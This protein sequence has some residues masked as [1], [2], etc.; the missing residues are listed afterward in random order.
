MMDDD[1]RLGPPDR[2]RQVFA[3]E[4]IGNDR[5]CACHLDFLPFLRRANQ[6]DDLVP[7][8]YQHGYQ[9]LTNCSCTSGYKYLHGSI[10]QSMNVQCTGA[11]CTTNPHLY[12]RSFTT[13]QSASIST[14][15]SGS[16]RRLTSTNVD[17]GRTSAK[18][19]P[20]ALAAS[21]QRETSV[22][23]TRVRTTSFFDP[24]AS[25][26]ALRMISRQRRVW[27]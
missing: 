26:T 7:I 3:V 13:K 22:S 12:S 9:N 6:C 14:S 27:P 25:L 21:S 2:S 17:A 16:M 8:G 4:W 19:S 10:I 20:C 5:P 15:Q 23:M 11:D 1:L 18:N 24:P